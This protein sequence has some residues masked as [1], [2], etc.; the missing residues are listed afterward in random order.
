MRLPFRPF[1][2]PEHT[3]LRL[4]GKHNG[5]A[6]L[7]HGFPG[8]PLEMRASAL[9]LHEQGWTV[10]AP[11]L[12]GFGKEIETLPEKKWSDWLQALQAEWHILRQSHSPLVLVG[13]SMGGALSQSLAAQ[14]PPDLLILFAPFWKIPG[15]L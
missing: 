6:L 4:P 3:P 8:T 14:Y 13:N 9:A 1:T 15:P 5:A 2:A 7:V 11:L 10:S 12:P